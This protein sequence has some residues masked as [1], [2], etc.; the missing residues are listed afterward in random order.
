[1]NKLPFK[2]Q[3]WT[4]QEWAQLK[5]ISKNELIRLLRRDPNWEEVHS[6]RGSRIVFRNRNLPLEYQYIAIH[7]HAGGFRNKSLLKALL[8]QIGWTADQ[9]RK[10]KVIK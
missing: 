9:L 5:G 3:K 2:P 6:S 7:R 8:A 4:S 10:W 1:M